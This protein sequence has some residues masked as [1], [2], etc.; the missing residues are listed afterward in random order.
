MPIDEMFLQE[1]V[2][3]NALQII[4]D[5]FDELYDGCKLGRFV[6]PKKGYSVIQDKKIAHDMINDFF[7]ARRKTTKQNY[8]YA[9][10]IKWGR[11][12]SDGICLQGI[13]R[14][15]RHTISK[16]I[17]WDIDISNAHPTIIYKYCLDNK[18]KVPT[19]QR[20][21]EKREELLNDLIGLVNGN[22]EH[23]TRDE[24]KTFPLAIINGANRSNWFDKDSK[25]DWIGLLEHEV[26]DIFNHFKST[27]KGKKF[28]K[29]ACD[30]K[31]YNVQGSTLNYFLC[32]QENIILCCM[33]EY[34][35]SQNIKVGVFCFDGMMV[36]KNK[37]DTKFPDKYLRGLEDAVKNELG[38]EL[39]IL[40]K[41][42]TEAID[43]TGY[44]K[45]PD[46]STTDEDLG[47]YF[48]E[49]MS[50]LYQSELNKLW[51]FDETERLWKKTEKE[52]LR[53]LLTKVIIPY[54][55][56]IKDPE[57]KEKA[58]NTLKDSPKQTKILTSVWGAIL[59]NPQDKFIKERFDNTLGLFP[60]SDGQ[61][62]NLKTT[63]VRARTKEDYFTRTTNREFKFEE[64]CDDAFVREYIGGILNTKDEKY[65]D[66]LLLVMGYS[67]TGENNLKR[68]FVLLG[69]KDTGK[70]LFCKLLCLIF[71]SW[72][73]VVNDKVF[74]ASKTESVHNT[75]AFSLMEK[76][77]AFVSEL[78]EKEKFNEQLIKKI[79][80]GDDVNLRGCG[81]NE[82]VCVN[83]NCILW[84]ATNGVPQFQEAAFA[85]RMRV[86]SFTTKFEN[87]PTRRDE[88]LS[89]VD[90]FFSVLCVMAKRYYD[91][92]MDFH[93]VTQVIQSTRDVIDD[94][95]SIKAWMEEQEDYVIDKSKNDQRVKKV[96][97]YTSYLVW[98]ECRKA[99]GVGR[100]TFY[101]RMKQEYDLPEYNQGKMY[102]GMRRSKF[103]E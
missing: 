90:D 59:S 32:E 24:A 27:E 6:D 92:G 34:L 55:E 53:P 87:N 66:Y 13:S 35:K 42:M 3:L 18:L 63:Q 85:G 31:D 97:V 17:Y 30:K 47:K 20:Y 86:I 2:D 50:W 48:L 88:I 45:Y 96:C 77:V 98:C 54:L 5:N 76:R 16:D 83:F 68:F 44:E 100:N 84:L 73:G 51:I 14:K 78:D 38:Y 57:L 33:Y 70:S 8:K 65:I 81:S 75:E 37:T 40:V 43:L 10:G 52:A 21:I 62:I 12:F 29:R 15:I 103:N 19:L 28:Y 64:E 58:I 7:K 82:N 69:E 41:P 80:G 23:L 22:G 89:K 39:K 25:P 9:T 56:G 36:Y 60:I 94:K 4:R 71:E 93:D 72:G 1:E 102:C 95:D 99:N 11:M 67:L 91:N 74:K 61:V 26:K 49:N 79:S 46:V 101:T